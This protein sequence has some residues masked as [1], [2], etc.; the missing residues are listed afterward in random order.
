MCSASDRLIIYGASIYTQ[1]CRK[2]Q[3]IRMGSLF[4][5]YRDYCMC[6]GH[7]GLTPV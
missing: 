1:Y 3:M 2:E 5:T 7:R 4:G 6:S